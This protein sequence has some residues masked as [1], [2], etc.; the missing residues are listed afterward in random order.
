MYDEIWGKFEE[1]VK[2]GDI[3]YYSGDLI[4]DPK[5][6][7]VGPSRHDSK[8]W[9]EHSYEK[10]N[11]FWNKLYFSNLKDAEKRNRAYRAGYNAHMLTYLFRDNSRIR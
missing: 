4:D 8:G 1:H 5:K 11:S 6:I 9:H 3:A 2:P 10:V 7:I